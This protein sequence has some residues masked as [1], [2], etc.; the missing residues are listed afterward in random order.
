MQ[1]G[2][3]RPSSLHIHFE[4]VSGAARNRFNHDFDSGIY[5]C[6]C[7]TVNCLYLLVSIHNELIRVV[8]Q[9]DCPACLSVVPGK[10]ENWRGEKLSFHFFS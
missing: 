2:P 1:L 6:C 10:A 7:T 5:S 9:Y 3:F 8:V 4:G